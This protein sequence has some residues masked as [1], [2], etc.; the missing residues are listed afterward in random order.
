M[1]QASLRGL[2][3]DEQPAGRRWSWQG[4]VVGGILGAVYGFIEQFPLVATLLGGLSIGFMAAL[5]LL[6]FARLLRLVS[7]TCRVPSASHD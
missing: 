3:A 2:G 1:N 7:P 4:A 6:L 5:A